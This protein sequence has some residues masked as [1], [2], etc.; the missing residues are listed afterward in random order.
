MKG[1]VLTRVR[2]SVSL[3]TGGELGLTA[4]AAGSAAIGMPYVAGRFSVYDT[5]AEISSLQEGRFMERIAH[6]A[7]SRTIR[8]DRAHMRLMFEHGR[9]PFIGTR[10]IAPIDGLGEDGAGVWYFGRLFDTV[11][12]RELRPLLEAG[13]L[14]SS[15][16]FSVDRERVD[17]RPVRSDRN[18][19]RLPERTILEA[20]VY[21][22]G[23]VVFPAYRTATAGVTTGAHPPR[24][25]PAM[26]FDQF[27]HQLEQPRAVT[28]AE[29]LAR[30]R[31]L[32]KVL[33][34]PLV[35]RSRR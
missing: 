28:A 16:R 19:E 2:G 29:R 18:P 24:S 9:D 5:W 11:A 35:A 31:W 4:T 23:P 17:D 15:F 12:A 6:G 13:V 22:F 7:F 10:P 25:T 32:D 30:Q 20:T 14:G 8:E 21:E 3:R 1:A 34:L 33:P 27:I 26:S